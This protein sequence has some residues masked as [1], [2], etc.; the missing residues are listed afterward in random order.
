MLRFLILLSLYFFT[1][2]VTSAQQAEDLPSTAGDIG[3]T[4]LDSKAGHKDPSLELNETLS[5]ENRF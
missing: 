4:L 2:Q 3:T 5:S 1:A